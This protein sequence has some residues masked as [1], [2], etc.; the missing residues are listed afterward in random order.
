MKIG[1]Y[2]ELQ[3]L[4]SRPHLNGKTVLLVGW[5][6]DRGRWQCKLS[7]GSKLN[8]FET[9]LFDRERCVRDACPSGQPCVDPLLSQ[10]G[11]PSPE[12]S[13][14]WP[15]TRQA[16]SARL[17]MSSP[18]CVELASPHEEATDIDEQLSQC[19]QKEELMERPH[20]SQTE[21]P[22]VREDLDIKIDPAP[23]LSLQSSLSAK[24]ETLVPEEDFVLERKLSRRRLRAVHSSPCRQSD[25]GEGSDD[26]KGHLFTSRC[27]HGGSSSS[28]SAGSSKIRGEEEVP[29]EE[30]S[31]AEQLSYP[32]LGPGLRTFVI[33]L[34]RRPD[35]RAHI[36][37][38]CKQLHLDYE[39]VEACDGRVLAAQEGARFEMLKPKAT[40]LV[41][42]DA[43]EGCPDQGAQDEERSENAPGEAE[44]RPNTHEAD[45]RPLGFRGLRIRTW[46]ARFRWK[47]KQTSQKLQMAEHRLRPSELTIAG[48]E[49]WG[50]V[51]C[52]LSH[53]EVLRRIASDPGLEWAL[54]LEDDAVLGLS[55]AAEVKQVFDHEMRIIAQEHPD[56]QLIYLG[57]NISTAVKKEEKESW[58]K[59]PWIKAAQQ[60]YQTHAFIIRRSLIPDILAKLEKGLAADAAF[61]SWSRVSKDKCFLF[62]PRKLLV[63]PGGVDRWKDSD[64]FI[65]GEF[66]KQAAIKRSGG[67][68]DF[69][70]ASTNRSKVTRMNVIRQALSPSAYQQ[71]APLSTGQLH[72]SA[73]PGKL[74]ASCAHGKKARASSRAGRQ[75]TVKQAE[76]QLR[77]HLKDASFLRVAASVEGGKAFKVRLPRQAKAK[78]CALE[79][80]Q[81]RL[82]EL[83][84]GVE[85]LVRLHHASLLAAVKCAAFSCWQRRLLA[86]ARFLCSP[87]AKREL[88]GS[89]GASQ[90]IGPLCE[91]LA[92]TMRC[93]LQFHCGLTDS[94]A[95][96]FQELHSASREQATKRLAELEAT[97]GIAAADTVSARMLLPEAAVMPELLE[98]LQAA[99][100][101]L[102]SVR[103]VAE[104]LA[105]LLS[106]VAAESAE[107]AAPGRGRKRKLP[108]TAAVLPSEGEAAFPAPLAAAASVLE[109]A[110]LLTDGSSAE[111][112]SAEP[113]ELIPGR[114]CPSRPAEGRSAAAEVSRKAE[115][116]QQSPGRISI[117]SRLEAPQSPASAC[118]E[119]LR[120][121]SVKELREQA[122][123]TGVHAL[124]VFGCVEKSDI[125]EVLLA[126]ASP[127][128]N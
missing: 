4:G 12:Q 37:A 76:L 111:K 56:W 62:H 94:A 21:A 117:P 58:Q 26:A 75:S 86:T 9:N 45:Q 95:E 79:A 47:G 112:S 23:V 44:P 77:K 52:N 16:S 102:T 99:N 7:N 8:V 59:S 48:H 20:S 89:L 84:E 38:L 78:V 96:A 2:V 31:P 43:C 67:T 87:S 83:L 124:H 103:R 57:G 74:R 88:K 53:Q 125:V 72:V 85:L 110:A 3:N 1:D 127:S 82:A 30:D 107:A 36:E 17:V 49:L 19:P 32:T 123:A 50:A 51:G 18:P 5:L 24:K 63:Q 91:R 11:P 100:S 71:Q 109:E 118:C 39:V 25:P 40:A 64:I 33:N 104:S 70:V 69:T 28:T 108:A 115:D 119:D 105:E 66:F 29:T 116:E 120:A 121:M 22:T 101:Q 126:E 106:A 15:L 113:T 97:L 61:V 114:F 65:E 98:Q 54:V 35:R 6:E 41:M 68:Y 27:E 122:R 80:L 13:P 81:A 55:S 46:C 10:P 128:R 34:A 90:P 42:S 14:S 93:F 60:V 92:V 73:P